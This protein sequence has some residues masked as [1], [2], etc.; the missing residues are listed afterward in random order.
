VLDE[1]GQV[2]RAQAAAAVG[3]QRLLGAGVGGLDGLAVVQVVVAVDAV[4]EQDARLGVVVGRAHDLVPQLARAHLAV[5]PHAVVALVGA[6]RLDVGGGLGLVHQLDV[7]V[8]STACMKASVTPTEML[9]L[10]RSPC[11]WR[12]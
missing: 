12:G 11:P 7:A 5:H 10:V 4:E 2:D 6:G 9:K 8:G 1:A 3:R